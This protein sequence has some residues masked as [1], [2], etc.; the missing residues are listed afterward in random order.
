MATRDRNHAVPN[1]P[2][3]LIYFNHRSAESDRSREAEAS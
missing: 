3:N 2:L 1:I